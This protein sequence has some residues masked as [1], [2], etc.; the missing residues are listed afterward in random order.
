MDCQH[1]KKSS[2]WNFNPD[3]PPVRRSTSQQ[4]LVRAEGQIIKGPDGR[5]HAAS[6]MF[7][8]TL[9]ISQLMMS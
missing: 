9:F 7:D 4:M 6:C 2:Y 1:I 8:F 3:W 5:S